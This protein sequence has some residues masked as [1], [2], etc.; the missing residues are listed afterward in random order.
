VRKAT[1]TRP[2]IVVAPV[3]GPL[4]RAAYPY[5][6]PPVGA[7]VRVA[8]VGSR[9]RFDAHVLHRPAAGVS[10][11]FVDFRAEGDPGELRAALQAAAPHVV[12]VLGAGSVP[13]GL[14]A[15]V[16]AATLG[17]VT[18]T[19][20]RPEGGANGDLEP[21]PSPAFGPTA[22]FDRIVTCDPEVVALAGGDAVW[23]SLPLPVDDRIY[24]SV[25]T[26]R[27]RPRPLFLGESTEYRERFLMRAKHEYDV[28]HYAHGLWGDALR[29]VLD[30]V[31]VGLNVHR[32]RRPR[33]ERRVLL[34]LAAG[35]LLVTEP[36]SPLHG[37]EP[38]IDF[39]PVARPDELLTVLGQLARR[40]E[41]HD[42]V[43]LRGRAKAEDYRAS[44]V[45]PRLLGDL[46]DDLAAFG[47]ERVT[48]PRQSA[49]RGG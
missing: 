15:D 2:S 1:R 44:R 4:D 10:P 31:D 41:L 37:L 5:A 42:R 46:L 28:L 33:F 19:V 3:P 36:L 7:P 45:W 48:A 24:G 13:A 14:L 18:Q 8:F 25:R 43:R 22:D 9:A 20:P 17:V 49:A 30:K 27:G 32:D 35:H 47:T 16:P 29:E 12:V 11:A 21:L 26:A 34:H 38:E 40:R 39:I 6:L 23:R